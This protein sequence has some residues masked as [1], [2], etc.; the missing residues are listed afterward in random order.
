[1]AESKF[2]KY[3]DT[4]GDGLVDACDDIVE[5]EQTS[6]CPEK[7]IPYGLASVPD[8]KTKTSDE[9]FLNERNCLYYVT[10][11]TRYNTTGADENSSNQEAAAA[12]RSIYAEYIDE[13]AGSLLANFDKDSSNDSIQKLKP[14]I[15][16]SN[17]DLDYRAGSRLR[18]LFTVSYEN[19]QS[20]DPASE[21][22]DELTTGETSFVENHKHQYEIDVFGNGYALVAANPEQPDIKHKHVVENF[23]VLEAQS[24]CYP[25]CKDFYDVS[26]I[27]PH[28][29]V[30]EDIEEQSSG[31]EVTYNIDDFKSK[32]L[33]VR[34]GLSLYSRYYRVYNAIDAGVFVFSTTKKVFTK[35]QFDSYG[36]IGFGP[37][38]L[39]DAY[40]QLD[41]FLSDRGMYLSSLFKKKRVTN[42]KFSF[43]QKYK[44]KKLE[45]TVSGCENKPYIYRKKTLNKT[46]N[47]KSAFKDPTAMAYLTKLN[48]MERDLR[49]REPKP[50]VE[51]MIEHTYPPIVERF[52]Y[53]FNRDNVEDT[54][55]GCVAG[56][57]EK[58]GKQ[59]GQ[60]LLDE[61]FGIGD[62]IAYNFH[63]RLCKKDN[64]DLDRELKDLGLK[65]DERGIIVKDREADKN[66]RALAKEQ[67]FRTMNAGDQTFITLCARFA[68]AGFSSGGSELLNELWVEGF[69]NLKV[70]GLTS[71]AMEAVS[72]IFGNLTLEESLSSIAKSALKGMDIENLGDL[73]VG[74]PPDKRNQITKLAETKLQRGQLF[75]QSSNLQDL[76]DQ[77]NATH[78]VPWRDRRNT[79]NIE[80]SDGEMNRRQ[81][82]RHTRRQARAENERQAVDSGVDSS[83]Q[84]NLAQQYDF[85]GQANSQLNQNIVI[86]AYISAMIEVYAG[87][88]LG[89]I[90][91]LNKY[92]GAQLIAKLLAPADCTK[93][94]FMD[95]NV[96]DFI[97]SIDLPFCQN[98]YD[99]VLPALS[100]PYG[101]I[102]KAKDLFK[103][104][105]NAI[106]EAIHQA[107]FNIVMKLQIKIC[108]LIG[109]SVCKTLAL[110]GDILLDLA[111]SG[112]TDKFKQIIKESLCGEDADDQQVEDA[113][114]D[115][116]EN[117]GPGGS[118]MANRD[119]MISFSEDISAATTRR[120]LMNAFLGDCSPEMLEV[121][122]GLIE[123][124]HPN[125]RSALPNKRAICDFFKG[126]GNVF[127]AD[128]KDAM[129]D[130]VDNL[131]EGDQLPANPSLCATDEQLEDFCDLRKEIMKGRATPGQIEKMCENARGTMKKD[132][133]D[134]Q[135][136]LQGGIPNHIA[137][138]MPPLISD[139]GCDNGIIPFEP[140]EAARASASSLSKQLE[141]LKVAY[142]KDLL[143]N[144]PGA[145]NW[146]LLNMIL[147]D[148]TGRP[149]TSHI[150]KSNL[151]KNYVDFYS[152]NDGILFENPEGAFPEKVA[153]WLQE[154]MNSMSE[155]ISFVSNNEEQETRK[156]TKT[157]S[158]LGIDNLYG[159]G[160]NYLELPDL[161]F[162]VI[163]E[164]DFEDLDDPKIIFIKPARKGSSDV[165]LYF[166]DNSKG[167]KTEDGYDFSE[168]FAIDFYLAD[169]I[170]SGSATRFASADNCRI[171][172]T[173]LQN[174]G[175]NLN[176]SALGL[177]SAAN[178]NSALDAL[179]SSSDIVTE[180]RFEF[181]AY[182]NTLSEVNSN[183]AIRGTVDTTKVSL[184][185]SAVLE[186]YKEFSAC[187][188]EQSEYIPQVVLL[189]EIL[190]ERGYTV[191]TGT[192]KDIYDE[193]MTNLLSQIISHV[194]GDDDN[195][196]FLFGAQYDSLS[197]DDVLYVVDG[198]DTLSDADTPYHEATVQDE[199]GSER[200]IENDDLIM[201]V[202]RMQW[203]Y[204][205]GVSDI[206]NRVFYLDPTKYG[207]SYVNPPVYV[208][209]VQNEGWLGMTNLVFPELTPCKPSR[210]DLVDFQ[211]IQDKIQENYNSIP[212][213][214]RLKA[215]QECVTELPYNKI[216][217]RYSAAGLEGLILS[218][219]RIFCSVHVIKSIAT[220]SKFKPDFDKVFSSIYAAYIVENM[221]DSF[222]NAQPAFWEALNPFKDTEFWYLF[223]EQCV[224]MYDR[225]MSSGEIID[226]PAA[227]VDAMIDINDATEEYQYQY[228]EQLQEA[229]D[230]G[231]V[232]KI[233]T[234]K[235]YRLDKKIEFIKATEEPAKVVLTQLIKE[236]LHVTG[237]KIITNLQDLNLNPK[238][239][240]L[241]YYVLEMLTQGGTP[242]ENTEKDTTTGL[243]IDKKIKEEVVEDLPTS[244]DDHY[245]SGG[246]FVVSV[247]NDATGFA[248]GEEY[249]GYYH[250]H[251]NEEGN[252]IYMSGE[253][254]TAAPHD[255]LKPFANKLI[256]PIGDVQEYGFMPSDDRTKFFAIEKYISINQVKYNTSEAISIIQ[257][258]NRDLNI[259]DVYP[260]TLTEAYNPEGEVV[261][262]IG[263]LGVRYGLQFSIVVRGEKVPLTTVEIDAIDLTIAQMAPFEG[264]SK[265]LLCLINLLKE[266][267]MFKLI[268]K[269]VFAMNKLTSLVAIYNDMGFLLSIGEATAAANTDKVGGSVTVT[270]TIENNK[271]FYEYDYQ[272]VNGWQHKKDRDPGRFSGNGLFYLHY[273][274]WDQELLSNSRARAKKLFKTYYNSKD[275]SALDFGVELPSIDFI[276]RLRQPFNP[277][278]GV[279]FFPKW[280][281]KKL[282]QNPFDANGQLCEK[283]ND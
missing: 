126:V 99:I 238:T 107:L 201:G 114:T 268:Y 275:M 94:P 210:T 196:A 200:L 154:Q 255:T 32:L 34:K 239:S 187:F 235:N 12:L 165:Q 178:A 253:F 42:I 266:D 83:N 87:D 153:E 222:L 241:G 248:E 278:P 69:N 128:V 250:V 48:E 172:I 125:Y 104:L 141:M 148:T 40:I 108:E 79:E 30:I 58:E 151:F 249:I 185:T 111:Q 208:K 251:Q 180:R 106:R 225:K 270:Q 149:Y 29:H 66:M 213:D 207:G 81:Q 245:T 234:L 46:L 62:A 70:C 124:E 96:F 122:D 163:T 277:R 150:R 190:N 161:G 51:F 212:E 16:N 232:S 281:L 45:V 223:L 186:N 145:K 140:E 127:P 84:R 147:S 217:D 67:A 218:T 183:P 198:G 169:L 274:K 71:L 279:Q 202:S 49:A 179:K 233:R 182:D 116:L 263:Q 229:K 176:L 20:M 199:D 1:M 191:S 282:K 283:N 226:P 206:E 35:D 117:L 171:S 269:Y 23:V 142:S 167:I 264:N 243:E 112:G 119:Q 31:A 256:L 101:W 195:P 155:S 100:N 65:V 228:R 85:G 193:L 242:P 254:H 15:E 74:L 157:F 272:Y 63:K 120:E 203:R 123:Y 276:K 25:N 17:F 75:K 230:I 194:A 38:V 168:G 93:P 262:L 8:W 139:P 159:A 72:C 18:L 41:Q 113:I 36:D 82:R 252:N 52:N 237:E 68:G 118:E 50:W 133:D 43:T 247:D 103:A 59:F 9:P 78:T 259:S 244:G 56:A 98:N 57:L 137:S 95:P 197:E 146:G 102:P 219:I 273:D 6:S 130:F 27:G 37:S 156:F 175:A 77:E 11:R 170:S 260:G 33:T 134:L 188:L 204:D 76:S 91:M 280:R 60:D 121:V 135:D 3:Q 28:V 90:D 143:N 160:I 92:P 44:L 19:L 109:K 64:E 144:G 86:E 224:Q 205:N 4:T 257:Q 132:M 258:N 214:E 164:V 131:P 39:E 231:E 174:H 105:Y 221:Q 265:M 73:F 246:Q 10:V 158:E 267:R 88:L 97:K 192:T 53:P 129:N 181:M 227:V 5:I 240:D 189:K 236:Q 209:P 21:D 115:L 138:N 211:D 152:E 47:K 110:G 22:E 2:L 177:M 216:L 220:F 7:C 136:L 61:V 162:N 80:G 173:S 14:F 13:A 215:D 271:A 26:G 54:A 184:D 261:G 24:D 55:E 89:L 166:E